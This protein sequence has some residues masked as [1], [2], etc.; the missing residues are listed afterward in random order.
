M[1]RLFDTSGHVI[2][3]VLSSIVL[4]STVCVSF[5][6]LVVVLVLDSASIVESSI[7]VQ[8]SSSSSVLRSFSSVVVCDSI[9]DSATCASVSSCACTGNRNCI[10]YYLL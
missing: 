2:N 3:V 10:Y 1:V 6:S 5:A 4:Y 8:T 7:V 9:F